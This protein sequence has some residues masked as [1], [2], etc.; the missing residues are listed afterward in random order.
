M[1]SKI[2]YK[3]LDQER[4]MYAVTKVSEIVDKHK[5]DD[6]F[7]GKYKA[8]AK[9]FSSI[10]REDLLQGLAFYFSKSNSSDE[11]FNIILKQIT[12]WFKFLAEK[13]Y[14]NIDSKEFEEP[15]KF[16]EYLTNVDAFE[17]LNLT[18]EAIQIGQWFKRFADALIEKEEDN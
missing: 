17:Y 6:N 18:Y 7:L 15:K 5:S 12:D 13:K 9:N 11:S 4:A 3:T 14:I 1:K 10:V 2:D 16:I 8:R